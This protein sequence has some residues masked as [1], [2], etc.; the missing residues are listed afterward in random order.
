LE[1]EAPAVA[2]LTLLVAEAVDAAADWAGFA[3]ETF[4]AADTA[5][6]ATAVFLTAG[7]DAGLALATGFF[8]VTGSFDELERTF[9]GCLPRGFHGCSPMANPRVIP[10]KTT[11]KRTQSYAGSHTRP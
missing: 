5:W 7:F 2:A 1:D 11:Q 3:V 10:L 8:T 4:F 6:L 9:N